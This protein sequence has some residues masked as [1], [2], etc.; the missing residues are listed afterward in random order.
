MLACHV[1]TGLKFVNI[2]WANLEVRALF[3]LL[4]LFS[5][6]VIPFNYVLTLFLVYLCTDYYR[7]VPESSLKEKTSAFEAQAYTRATSRRDYLEK[8]A[9]GL[10]KVENQALQSSHVGMAGAA[11]IHSQPAAADGA[12]GI[13][14]QAVLRQ[15]LQQQAEQQKV[16]LQQR[17]LMHQQMQQQQFQLQAQQMMLHQRQHASPQQGQPG[18][19][20]QEVGRKGSAASKRQPVVSEGKVSLFITLMTCLSFRSCLLFVFQRSVQFLTFIFS[21]S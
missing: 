11:P 14:A 7:T 18:I 3:Y 4:F 15:Q 9:E 19:A 13:Q 16:S 5:P 1:K 8:I 2:L 20:K 17:Q 12:A 10:S 6:T 21:S